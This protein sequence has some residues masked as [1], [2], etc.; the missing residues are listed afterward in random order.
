MPTWLSRLTLNQALAALAIGLGAIAL[1]AQ[2]YQGD[3]VEIDT[4][5][6]A[7]EIASGSADVEPR[8]LAAWI[9]GSRADYRVVDI[10]SAAV[11]AA[12]AVPGAE[13]IPVA[14][15]LDAGLLRSEK[16]IVVGDDGA[17]SAQA[18]LLLRA[19]GYR[20]A[21]VLKGGMA[22]WIDQVVSPVLI[23]DPTPEQKAENDKRSVI[24]AYFGGTPRTGAGALVAAPA[25]PAVG[26]VAPKVAPP[27]APAAGGAKAPAKKKR[28]GC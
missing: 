18:W 10:R 23:E 2:P 12:G 6:L 16:L 1:F 9:V 28:E 20:G 5:A 13:N 3:T 4:A 7:A 26:A 15:L 19:K 27:V 21:K 25:M 17:Q 22:G 24:A 14:G 11:F 8:I